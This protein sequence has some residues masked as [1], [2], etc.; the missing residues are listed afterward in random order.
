MAETMRALVIDRTGEA[1]ELHLAD[2]PRPL[3]ISDEVRR[4]GGGRRR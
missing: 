2:V 1:D 4:A 3:R